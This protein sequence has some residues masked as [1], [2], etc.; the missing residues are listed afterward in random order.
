MA[1]NLRTAHARGVLCWAIALYLALQLSLTLVTDFWRP[2]WRHP[3][4][5]RKLALLKTRMPAHGRAPDVL[6]LGTSRTAFG[7][8]PADDDRVWEFNFG[9]TGIGPLQQFAC[10]RRLLDEGVRPGRLLI[11]IHPPLL[12]QT[13]E[14]NELRRIDLARLGWTDLRVLIGYSH[15]P[16]ALCRRW[17]IS[18]LGATYTHRAVLV[19]RWLPEWLDED[20]RR[21][22]ARL[23]EISV[24]GWQPVPARPTDDAER[25]RMNAWSAGLYAG[26]WKEFVISE[27]P[28]QA[29]DEMLDLCR[30]ERIEA[31]LVLLPE[32]DEFRGHYPAA[33]WDRLHDYLADVSRSRGVPVFDCGQW[34]EESHI[35]D[36]QH[37]LPEGAAAF[38]ARLETDVLRSWRSRR[39]TP[40]TIADR[41]SGA[42]R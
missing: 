14:W 32:G 20:R 17:V 26:A 21:E 36:G 28:R 37:L 35:C 38:S 42:R 11:E 1:R 12:H 31:A 29:V 27:F 8:R 19:R 13:P 5:G 40:T 4:Y 33:A 18:R 7:F 2:G 25:R 10:L 30:R 16:A 23:D 24:S 15:T 22:A 6:A 39:A 9:L 34:C 3:E 41:A